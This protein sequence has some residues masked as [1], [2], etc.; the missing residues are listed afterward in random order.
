[1][2]LPAILI[3]LAMSSL[4]QGP[5][6]ALSREEAAELAALQTR[7]AQ[8]DQEQAQAR[9]QADMLALRRDV[10][11]RDIQIYQLRVSLA[12]KPAPDTVFDSRSLTWIPRP[13]Q[14]SAPS[15]PAKP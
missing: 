14:P 2:K 15:A 10:L 9:K 5:P 4:A 12:H 1:V 13:V 8:L 3:L 7:R 11:D 6:F